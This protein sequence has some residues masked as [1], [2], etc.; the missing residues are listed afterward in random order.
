M[1]IDYSRLSKIVARALRHAPEQFGIELDEEG[2]TPVQGLLAALRKRPSKWKNLTD[3]DLRVMME[4]SI[5]RRYEMRD[6]KIRA[7]YGHSVR[8]TIQKTSL[9]RKRGRVVSGRH[10]SGVH[11]G[12][13]TGVV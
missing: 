9:S 4:R 11:Q 5:K 8:E 3:A 13:L 2:W 1:T 12:S 10:S 6:G 7:T